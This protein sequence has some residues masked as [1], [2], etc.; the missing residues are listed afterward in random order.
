M[1]EEGL[2]LAGPLPAAPHSPMTETAI[3]TIL[4]QRKAFLGFVE[5][6]VG[7]HGLAEDILQA[8]YV[9]ALGR[10][11]EL[12]DVGDGQSVVA[13]FYRVLRNAVIDQYRRRGTENKAL[14]AWGRELEMTVDPSREEQ[15]EIC[16]CLAE[17]VQEL[18][19]E[20][21][22]VIQA[23]DLGEQP[24]TEF[25]RERGLSASNA[26]VRAHR[27][28]AALR[29][30]LI[31]TCGSCSADP[32]T[33]P[34]PRVLSCRTAAWVRPQRPREPGGPLPIAVPSAVAPW[35]VPLTDA[36]HSLVLYG[37]VV[38]GLA[39][40]AT[41]LRMAATRR[42]VTPRYRPA[43]L[44]GMQVTAVAFT[45]YV[46]I[47]VLFLLGYDRIGTLWRPND[48]AMM[49][50]AARFMDWSV[51]VPLLVV[52]LVAV[53]SLAGPVARRFRLV[54]ASAAFL[55]IALGFIGGV[56]VE[57]GT[58][59][60][61]LAIQVVDVSAD[62]PNRASDVRRPVALATSAVDV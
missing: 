62:H 45:S 30:R 34:P 14:E 48:A 5:R 53:S 18:K 60:V 58:D 61:A 17:A 22:E 43:T 55:M 19:P 15:D 47:A 12:E 1:R 28:R 27:A 8:A 21:A 13:W 23:V 7:D 39:L 4:A 11:A 16:G 51:S 6:R 33:R 54:G 10:E 49:S 9:R 25:A 32:P 46:L 59:P 35:N 2:R 31:E 20:Y 38:A 56:V 41:L 42:D 26:G 29:K 37:I 57:G 52:E 24:L 3:N 36:E 40:G 50:W 44:A